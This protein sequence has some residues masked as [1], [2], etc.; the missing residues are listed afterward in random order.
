ANADDPKKVSLMR[1]ARIGQ[2]RAR[3]RQ[4]AHP[5]KLI[6]GDDHVVKEEINENHPAP[7]SRVQGH[8]KERT[9]ASCYQSCDSRVVRVSA[10]E[11]FA[12]PPHP[13]SYLGKKIAGARETS[14]PEVSRRRPR[15][16]RE[17]N[18]ALRAM[19]QDNTGFAQRE[20]GDRLAL[21]ATSSSPMSPRSAATT[22]PRLTSSVCNPPRRL[23]RHTH[24]F[25][26]YTVQSR[27]RT[28]PPS[29]SSSPFRQPD[30]III[31]ETE[32]LSLKVHGQSFMMHQIRKMVGLATLV[33]R[34]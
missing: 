5:Q 33:T 18:K 16:G 4:R 9:K 8:S 25:H 26:N 32:W 28:R 17:A 22:S 27:S 12:A 2:G 13:D 23:P 7:D 24:N 31:G 29:A 10:A 1:C 19:P 6:D 15:I 14:A 30:P 11:L 21:H 34:F 3:R 20:L